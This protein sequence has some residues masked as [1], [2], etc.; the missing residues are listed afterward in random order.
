MLSVIF[1]EKLVGTM[2][3][4]AN[5]L[6]LG[7]SGAILLG[8]SPSCPTSFSSTTGIKK[9]CC[10]RCCIDDKVLHCRKGMDRETGVS[11]RVTSL[12]NFLNISFIPTTAYFLAM[13]T[14]FF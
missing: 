11:D 1:A 14:S 10:D 9:K 12:R 8:S 7:A 13:P 6:A 2:A 4:L 3:K 5:A